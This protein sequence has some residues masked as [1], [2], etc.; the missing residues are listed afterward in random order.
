MKIAHELMR[1]MHGDQRPETVVKMTM[2]YN[3]GKTNNGRAENVQSLIQIVHTAARQ[4][5]V[6]VKALGAIIDE[7]TQDV[8]IDK[9]QLSLYSTTTAV[10]HL[11]CSLFKTF[12]GFHFTGWS[13][14]CCAR[15]IQRFRLIVKTFFETFSRALATD[16]SGDTLPVTTNFLS[17]HTW[18]LRASKPLWSLEWPEGF[19]Q[20]CDSRSDTPCLM[21]SLCRIE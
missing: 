4:E 2:A 14:H 19:Q 3:A 16:L 15:R 21:Q 17:K 9:N 11:D 10:E 1:R 8:F 12:I 6:V 18:N 5:V 13:P 20:V 7:D